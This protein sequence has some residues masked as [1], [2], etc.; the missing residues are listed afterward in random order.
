MGAIGSAILSSK[1]NINKEFDLNIND[2][3]FETKGFECSGC[4]NNCEIV[5]IFKDIKIIDSFGN[6]CNKILKK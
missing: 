4:S 2:I 6:R 5:K 3:K 1:D